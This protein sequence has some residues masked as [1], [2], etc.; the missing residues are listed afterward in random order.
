[1]NKISLAI[2]LSF[3]NLICAQI[4][5]SRPILDEPSVTTSN[6]RYTVGSDIYLPDETIGTPYL[7]EVFQPGVI[8]EN[9]K[10]ISNSMFFRYNVIEDDI[11]VKKSM[12]EADSEIMILEKSSNIYVKIYDDILIFDENFNGYFQLMFVGN[13]FNLYKKRN[14][15]LKPAKIAS[16]SFEKDILASYYDSYTYFLMDNKNGMHEIPT[17]KNKKIKFFNNKSSKIK[18]YLKKNNLD[19]NNEEVLI[20]I[21]RYFDS[22][23]DASL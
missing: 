4:E 23:K 21:V 19:I 13:N 11:E 10:E 5:I 1:M 14:K 9:N 7:E 17:S 6:V 2:F 8:F 3:T 15:K 22:F 12:N 20:K 16:T 18:I